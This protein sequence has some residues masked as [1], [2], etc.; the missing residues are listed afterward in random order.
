MRLQLAQRDLAAAGVAQ[1]HRRA[2]P[3]RNRAIQRMASSGSTSGRSASGV[4]GRGLRKLS[5]TSAGLDL[6]Q[7][8]EQLEALLVGLAHAEQHAAAQLHAVLADQLA[9]VEALLP[10]VGGDDRGKNERAVSRL[11]L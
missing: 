11:W 10:R 4:P 8:A 9:G 7:L 6:A 5:G 1:D 3:R 2:G